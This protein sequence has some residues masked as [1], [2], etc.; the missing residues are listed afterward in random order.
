MA[1]KKTELSLYS[2]S[3]RPLDLKGRWVNELGSTMT[4]AAVATGGHFEW[5]LSDAAG[6]RR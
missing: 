5:R 2:T 6:C 4:I 1:L 3:R